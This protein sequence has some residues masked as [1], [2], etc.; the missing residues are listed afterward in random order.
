MKTYER[1]VAIAND[2]LVEGVYMASGASA[3]SDCYTVNA[4]IHQR[5]ETGREDYRIQVNAA[6]AATDKHHSGKQTLIISFN[7]PVE[8]ISCNANGASLAG[9]NN[10]NTLEID[11]T[12]HNNASDNIGFGDLVVKS[13]SGLAITGSELTCNHDCGQH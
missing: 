7:Q 4:Y 2:E 13:E 12:Y 8:Y 6:H 11:M 3:G 10:T 5:P 9:G 1:P